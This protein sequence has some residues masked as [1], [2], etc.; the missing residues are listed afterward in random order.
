MDCR[1][2]PIIIIV[3]SV[4]YFLLYKT[5]RL[6][7]AIVAGVRHEAVLCS[8]GKNPNI[9]RTRASIEIFKIS[10]GIAPLYLIHM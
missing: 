8:S 1:N 5:R 6:V 7:L 10:V 9:I 4:N 3:D 2:C